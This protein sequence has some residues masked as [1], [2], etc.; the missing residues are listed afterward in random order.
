MKRTFVRLPRTTAPLLAVSDLLFVPL[1]SPL[2][3]Q[4]QAQQRSNR[5]DSPPAN[6]NTTTTSFCPRRWDH[7]TA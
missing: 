3:A 6:I 5:N 1:R 2:S 7:P 4:F